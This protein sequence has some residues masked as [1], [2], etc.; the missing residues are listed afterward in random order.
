MEKVIFC[1]HCKKSTDGLSFFCQSCNKIQKPFK[2]EAYDI[3]E[4][5]QEFAIDKNTLEEKYLNLQAKLHPDKFINFSEIEKDYATSHSSNIN[6][7]YNNLVNDVKRSQTLLKALGYNLDKEDKSFDDKNI[8][9]EIMELQNE[10]MLAERNHE[11]V[12][13]KKKILDFIDKTNKKIDTLIKSKSLD[14]AHTL[15]IKLSYLEKIRQNLS[16][17]N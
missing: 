1:W 16:N 17:N 4:L 7:A 9:N 3:F 10:C 6:D 14:D 13:I 5:N 2:I 12:K 11:K 15:T 8:L